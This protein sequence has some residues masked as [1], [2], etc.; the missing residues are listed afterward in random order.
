VKIGDMGLARDTTSLTKKGNTICGTL[1]YMSPQ[2]V[3]EEFYTN[4]TDVWSFGCVVYELITLE[5]AFDGK[6]TF[7]ETKIHIIANNHEFKKGAPGIF[8]SILNKYPET[9]ENINEP[10]RIMLK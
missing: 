10:L 6:V 7:D 9:P 2:L 3:R 8:D 5:K 4:K 1:N